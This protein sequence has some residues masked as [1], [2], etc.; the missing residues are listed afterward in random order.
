LTEHGHPDAA[1]GRRGRG[2]LQQHVHRQNGPGAGSRSLDPEDRPR[3]CASR[4][5][6]PVHH[7]GDERRTIHGDRRRRRRLGPRRARVRLHVSP[8]MVASPVQITLSAGG[9]CT[10]GHVQLRSAKRGAVFP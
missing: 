4:R 5:H 9:Q 3:H 2:P 7:R 10:Q 6:R 8:S 1:R